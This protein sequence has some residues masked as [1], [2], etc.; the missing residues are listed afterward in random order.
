MTDESNLCVVCHGQ[1]SALACINTSG[2]V[3]SRICD[4]PRCAEIARRWAVTGAGND[5]TAY[6][7]LAM[8]SAGK[9]AGQFLARDL[10]QT[11][12]A[13]L[14]RVQWAA[15]VNRMIGAYRADLQ[16]LVQEQ[17]PPF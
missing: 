17:A 8:M 5:F 2:E 12:M 9:A 4:D 16:K 7:R 6:E 1:A 14:T 11:D 15:F 10:G 13:Q 3:I